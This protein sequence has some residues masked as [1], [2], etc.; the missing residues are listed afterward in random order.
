MSTDAERGCLLWSALLERLSLLNLPGVAGVSPCSDKSAKCS[1]Q[2]EGKG[3]IRTRHWTFISPSPYRQHD[4][5]TINFVTILV[6][7]PLR[8]GRR[9]VIVV[10]E[11]YR[12]LFSRVF[13]G[14]WREAG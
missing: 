9:R 14:W 12:R 3:S 1:E 6:M 5:N 10:S 8:Q 2:E 7:C 13:G 4:A 11:H